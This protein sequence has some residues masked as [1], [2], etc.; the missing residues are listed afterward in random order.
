MLCLAWHGEERLPG[1]KNAAACLNLYKQGIQRDE[2]M[3]AHSTAL[4]PLFG[5]V[6]PTK[7]CVSCKAPL[8]V[9]LQ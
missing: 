5:A 6:K 2:H 4:V 7:L 3:H 9:L 8:Q 1:Q